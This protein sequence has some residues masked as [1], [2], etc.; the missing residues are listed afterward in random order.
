[1]QLNETGKGNMMGILIHVPEHT[2]KRQ[3]ALYMSLLWPMAAFNME[4]TKSHYWTTDTN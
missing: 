4:S 1:M 3:W 2:H